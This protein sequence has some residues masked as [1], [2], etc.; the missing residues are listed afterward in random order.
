MSSRRVLVEE[1]LRSWREQEQTWFYLLEAVRPDGPLAGWVVEAAM[2]AAEIHHRPLTREHKLSDSDTAL[3]RL[4][5]KKLKSTTMTL[6]LLRYSRLE[7]ALM[8]LIAAKFHIFR[9]RSSASVPR[10]PGSKNLTS[11]NS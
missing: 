5:F 4:I 10:Q 2:R 9:H 11:A 6:D 3:V 8:G 1:R 7:K